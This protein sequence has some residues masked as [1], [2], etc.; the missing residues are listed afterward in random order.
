MEFINEWYQLIVTLLLLGITIGLVIT[1]T[2]LMNIRDVCI[3]ISGKLS[4]E[5]PKTT[6]TVQEVSVV[7]RVPV[8]VMSDV[9]VEIK[10]I[11]DYAGPMK[12]KIG[13][14]VQVTNYVGPLDVKVGSVQVDNVVRTT[15]YKEDIY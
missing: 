7:N 2:E 11:A 9:G 8:D 6:N 1:H 13:D 5:E 3:T 14:P 12:V 10:G 4:Y 15:P